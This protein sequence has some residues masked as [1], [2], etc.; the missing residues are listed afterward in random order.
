M[1]LGLALAIAPGQADPLLSLTMGQS[2]DL[3]LQ[4][5]HDMRTSEEDIAAAE[6]RIREARSA[7]FPGLDLSAAYNHTWIQPEA[8]ITISGEDA[9]GNT[10]KQTQTVAFGQPNYLSAG[11]S[12][13]QTLY[14]GGKVR[15]GLVAAEVY[16]DQAR[17]RTRAT[18]HAISYQVQRTF[19]GAAMAREAIG[20]A[21][22][23]LNQARQHRD[24]V[25]KRHAGGNASEFDLLRADV[26]VANLEPPLIEA[27]N[28]YARTTEQLKAA[29]GLDMSRAVTVEA[30]LDA[31]A[32][33]LRAATA[34]LLAAAPPTHPDSLDFDVDA[35]A[36]LA[37]GARAEV[38]ALDFQGRLL[39]EQLAIDR[40]DRR[41]SVALIGQYQWEWQLPNEWRTRS[42]D[43]T[44]SWTTGLALSL[45]LYDGG[46]T[47][48][49][50]A[51][52]RAAQRQV[53][54]ARNK[55]ED[56]IYLEV[57]NA[58]LDLREA[59]QKIRAQGRTVE[60]AERAL[61]IADVRFGGG[62]ATQLEVLD[63]QLAVTASRTQQ[64]KATHD[65]AVALATV[66]YATGHT[67]PATELE[68]TR[69]SQ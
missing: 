14:A 68:E 6:A 37:V 26:E 58:L 10:V 11:I 63:A 46:R 35:L 27:R 61:A 66:A 34:P 41:P 3:A 38:E 50:V 15:N 7:A 69:R 51:Q 13:Q 2:V 55:L 20:V 28:R 36:R 59:E 30:D 53:E 56:G 21:E 43:L 33:A 4:H 5:N 47:R 18:R 1:G 57:R 25:A 31:A 49:R 60:Q 23:A 40:G 44:D 62:M 17:A 19:L 9:D 39:Q 54:I 67:I 52:T 24:Q 16:A 29:I 22:L 42:E 12:L 8:V 48:A 64:I 32:A 45:P 65:Y